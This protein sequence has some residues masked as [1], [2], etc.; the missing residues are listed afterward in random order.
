PQPEQ[1]V[2]SATKTNPQSQFGLK[3]K[4]EVQALENISDTV[5]DVTKSARGKKIIH[6]KSGAIWQQ[7]DS[8]YFKLEDGMSVYIERGALGSFY[9][10]HE[11]VNRRIKVK[12]IK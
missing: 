4:S 2:V 8:A 1:P 7:V 5:V 9:L 10:S 11:E 6:M 12:R 3:V